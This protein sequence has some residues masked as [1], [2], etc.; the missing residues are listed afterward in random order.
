MGD[1]DADCRVTVADYPYFEFC[2]WDSGP[3]IE[4]LFGDC[5]GHLIL[6]GTKTLTQLITRSLR[7]RSSGSN[8]RSPDLWMRCP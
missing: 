3:G 1:I 5:L 6:M 7:W 2:F 4:P 8:P